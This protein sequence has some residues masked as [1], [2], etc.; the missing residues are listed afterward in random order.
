MAQITNHFCPRTNDITINT[1]TL[2]KNKLTGLNDLEPF[3]GKVVKFTTNEG[4]S[5]EYVLLEEPVYEAK[6]GKIISAGIRACTTGKSW[7]NWTITGRILLDN[8]TFDPCTNGHKNVYFQTAAFD[9]F[10]DLQFARHEQLDANRASLRAEPKGP[11]PF[12]PTNEPG[13]LPGMPGIFLE[14]PF[15]LVRSSQGEVDLKVSLL[16]D[17]IFA[18]ATPTYPMPKETIVT[19]GKEYAWQVHVN[20]DSTLTVGEKDQTENVKLIWWEAKRNNHPI[21]LNLNESV[22]IKKEELPGFLHAVL[23]KKG[24]SSK[25]RETFVEYWQQ[26]FAHDENIASYLQVQLTNKEEHNV[27]LPP[28]KVD[29]SSFDV[30]R[31]YF[32]FA[33]MQETMEGISKDEYLAK[34]ETANVGE[35]AILDLGGEII[36]LDG[37]TIAADDKTDF[38]QAFINNHIKV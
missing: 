25:E 24:L 17:E 32:R 5:F 7:R 33:P 18:L 8:N 3:I 36:N 6:N 35:N 22:C 11:I 31:F 14:A 12:V 2:A 27:L 30:K 15:T 1:K 10:K 34:L 38:N 16:F 29:N 9:E 23:A 37:T 20:A 4:A 21:P 19:E 13:I 26:R 28:M